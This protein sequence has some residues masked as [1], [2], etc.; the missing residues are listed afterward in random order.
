[1]YPGFQFLNMKKQVIHNADYADCAL[2]TP[3]A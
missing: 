2:D 3:Q 1:L